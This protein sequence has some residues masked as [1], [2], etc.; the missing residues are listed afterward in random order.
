M[1]DMIDEYRSLKTWDEK[2]DFIRRNRRK[3]GARTNV[4]REFR[5]EVCD[6]N[7]RQPIS[8]PIRSIFTGRFLQPG[9]YQYK[10]T[11]QRCNIVR[12]HSFCKDFVESG[13][14]TLTDPVSGRRLSRRGRMARRVIRRCYRKRA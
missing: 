8:K 13:N 14:D 5:R 6:F 4:M 7:T 2:I 11:L 3:L 1:S 9:T 10:K 12:H